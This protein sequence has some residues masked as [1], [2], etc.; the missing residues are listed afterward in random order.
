MKRPAYVCVYIYIMFILRIIKTENIQ[1]F[2]MLKLVAHLVATAT[3]AVQFRKVIIT[4][5]SL[6]L[7]VHSVFQ[8]NF[9]DSVS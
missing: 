2:N 1:S 5:P 3:N 8:N 6:L 4:T 9:P 7:Q